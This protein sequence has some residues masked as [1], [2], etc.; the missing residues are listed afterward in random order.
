M[1]KN[2]EL[3]VGEGL[4]TLPQM[5]NAKGKVQ[6]EGKDFLQKS[7]EFILFAKFVYSEVFSVFP[8]IKKKGMTLYTFKV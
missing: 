3:I 4:K 5:Q 7:L 6:N 8:P 2:S 1:L